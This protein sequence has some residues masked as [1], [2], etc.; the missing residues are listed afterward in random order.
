[1][2]RWF[3]QRFQQRI[4]GAGGKHVNLVDYVDFIAGGSGPVAHRINNLSNVAHTGTAGGIHLQNIHMATLCDCH[5]GFAFA[6]RFDRWATN[7]IRPRAIQPFGD[8]PRGGGFAGS[9]NAG[10]NK[11]VG[12][13]VG[14][15]RIF[16]RANHG[17]LTVQVL[18]GLGA[19]FAGQ[20]LIG[21]AGIFGFTHGYSPVLLP[22]QHRHRTGKKRGVFTGSNF[23]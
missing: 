14:L 10:H 22:R 7:A 1:M 3:F 2:F 4:E 21:L 8:N 23:A 5:T 12:N 16:E 9:A 20:N 15:K 18:E 6:A 13:P 17:L 19:V 11:S